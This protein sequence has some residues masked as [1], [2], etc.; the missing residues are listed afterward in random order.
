M[1]DSYDHI[2]SISEE[3]KPTPPPMAWNRIERRLSN[4][5]SKNKRNRLNLIRFW[6]SIAASLMIIITCTYIIYQESISPQTFGVEYV[7]EWEDLDI[8][9]DY[10]YSIENARSINSILKVSHQN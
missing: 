2:K 5:Q 6:F 10:L 4:V 9:Q 1:S 8:K 7:A 3:F